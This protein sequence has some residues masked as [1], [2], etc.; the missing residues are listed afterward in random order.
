M[1][2]SS[3]AFSS[4]QRLPN[5]SR[6]HRST[7]KTETSTALNSTQ[8]IQT[9]RSHYRQNNH[10]NGSRKQAQWKPIQVHEKAWE[11]H[12]TGPLPLNLRHSRAY[13]YPKPF[14]TEEVTREL[15]YDEESKEHHISNPS[16][17]KIKSL[18]IQ[19][20][21][22][23]VPIQ[24]EEKDRLKTT[25][26]IQFQNPKEKKCEVSRPQTQPSLLEQSALDYEREF[27]SY[28]PSFAPTTVQTP[29]NPSQALKKDRR[30]EKKLYS[31]ILSQKEEAS[32]QA[33]DQ[34][35]QRVLA[36]RYNKIRT[37]NQMNIEKHNFIPTSPFASV[38]STATTPSSSS[39]SSSSH[40]S[41]FSAP[42]S[43][44]LPSTPK[45][46][47]LHLQHQSQSLPSAGCATDAL[48]KAWDPTTTRR[49]TKP[50]E[51]RIKQDNF[52]NTFQR[53]ITTDTQSQSQAATSNAASSPATATATASSS[54]SSS[55]SSDRYISTTHLNMLGTER[56]LAAQRASEP[57]ISAYE[58]VTNV[59]YNPRKAAFNNGNTL[60]DS[61]IGKSNF[62]TFKFTPRIQY[63]DMTTPSN[64]NTNTTSTT[65]QPNT[66]STTSTSTSASIAATVSA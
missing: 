64:T 39:S 34:L 60:I 1:S 57:V 42:T 49:L 12:Q 38:S 16:D 15:L 41:S 50:A 66:T 14:V 53:I 35:F 24:I 48:P 62:K 11:R 47:F 58:R 17:R 2:Q 19:R 5:S 32:A 25:T 4:T 7:A 8:R 26:Q 40:S 6:V 51:Q 21:K 18:T 56:A 61:V 65:S 23:Q 3:T 37:N 54:T 13:F 22:P 36:I 59:A 45:S 9:D 43:V 31:Q 10:T 52:H 27:K 44:S 28:D 55:S 29:A 33:A 20:Y 46:Y 30:E 63:V